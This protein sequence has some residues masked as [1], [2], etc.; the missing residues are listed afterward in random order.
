MTEDLNRPVERSETSSEKFRCFSLIRDEKSDF[1]PFF[2]SLQKLFINKESIFDLNHL[3]CSGSNMT[4]MSNQKNCFP[5]VS[6]EI[7]KKIQNFF[8]CF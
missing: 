6:I 4:I 2:Q 3:F 7:L 8:S 1:P 5:L